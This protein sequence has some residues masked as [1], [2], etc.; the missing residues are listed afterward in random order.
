MLRTAGS[1]CGQAIS[2]K[3][4]V[5][6]FDQFV[7]PHVSTGRRG[8]A[9]TLG[10]HKSFNYVLYCTRTISGRRCRSKRITNAV[11]KFTTRAFIGSCGDSKAPLRVEQIECGPDDASPKEARHVPNP[12][13]IGTGS[14]SSERSRELGALVAQCLDGRDSGLLGNLAKRLGLFPRSPVARA[15]SRVDPVE[16][17]AEVGSLPLNVRQLCFAMFAHE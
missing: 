13:V 4:S 5:E 1:Q 12:L 3:F 16:Q 11:L 14:P 17:G 10:L 15:S 6:Q 2:T 8:P 7:L 9:P